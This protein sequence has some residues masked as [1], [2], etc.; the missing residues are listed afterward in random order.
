[1]VS[2]RTLRSTGAAG[3]IRSSAR[4]EPGRPAGA[5]APLKGG[6]H[7]GGG[8]GW[9]GGERRAA[10]GQ[11]R[12][13]TRAGRREPGP[14]ERGPIMGRGGRAAR[15]GLRIGASAGVGALQREGVPRGGVGLASEAAD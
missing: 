12:A 1:M 2:S 6:D 15:G 8:G 13:V 14:I 5:P 3:R 11:A 10:S 4:G 9:E 7:G